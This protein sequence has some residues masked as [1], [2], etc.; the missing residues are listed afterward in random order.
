MKNKTHKHKEKHGTVNK[1]YD[2]S[3]PKTDEVNYV[4]NDTIKSCKDKYFHS[5]EYR[6]VYDIKFIKTENIEEIFL[7]I[8]L[9]Y[10][11]YKSQFY[12]LSTSTKN[13]RINCFRFSEIVK[14]TIKNDSSLSNIKIC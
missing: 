14:L 12:G 13:A 1:E 11:K 7:S 9:G 10:M 6:C 3:N 2:S 5:F 8:T 4:L